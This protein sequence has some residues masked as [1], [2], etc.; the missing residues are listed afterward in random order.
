VAGALPPPDALLPELRPLGRFQ[1]AQIHRHVLEPSIDVSRSGVPA[2]F[3]SRR[4]AIL[5]CPV[6]LLAYRHEVPHLV[7][8][9]PGLR[10]I[11]QLDRVIDPPQPHAL[12]GLR[13]SLVE[14]DGAL[15]ARH[16]EALARASL[17][18]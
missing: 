2:R 12:D 16:L 18:L 11:R 13:L 3:V 17:V 1:I 5:S 10:R 4:S 6:P 14:A 7:N 15:D 9:P 8:H